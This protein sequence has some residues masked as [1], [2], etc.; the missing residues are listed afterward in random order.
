MEGQRTEYL[1]E[2]YSDMIL[3]LGYSWL[4]DMDD[5]MDGLPGYLAITQAD[6]V[7]LLQNL[8]W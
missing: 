2:Q 4:G 1:M 6:A 3:R 5:A 7:K 8:P